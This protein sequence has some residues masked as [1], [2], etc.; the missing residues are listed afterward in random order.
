MKYLNF[1]RYKFSTALK[2]IYLWIANFSKI[3]KK[4]D[5]G[6][7]NFNK[8]Y[9]Y[10]D[11]R[12]YNF[13][14][15]YKYV[16]FRR[17]NIA[18]ISKF[19][20]IKKY[21]YIPI[22]IFSFTFLIFFVYLSIPIFFKYDKSFIEKICKNHNIKCFIEGRIKYTFFPSPRIKFNNLKIKDFNNKN[23]NLTVIN[24]VVIKISIT[25]L[26]DKRKFNFTKVELQNAEVNFDLK[27]FKKYKNFI[28]KKSVSKAISLKKGEINFF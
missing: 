8:V 22:Y 11:F 18:K 12:R 21:K 23:K 17:Y 3:Y 2:K 15:V 28:E 13:N 5:Y 24:D 4:I 14:K 6:R 7:Y 27:E 1:K 16:D 10:V 19:F 9:K 26:F 25:Q 20:D